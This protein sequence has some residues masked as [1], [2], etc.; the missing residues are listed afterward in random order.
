MGEELSSLRVEDLQN[1]ETQ[2]EMSLKGIR[3]KKVCEY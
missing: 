1:L 2:L 3:E